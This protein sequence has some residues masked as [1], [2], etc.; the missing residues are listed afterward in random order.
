MTFVLVLSA[1]STSFIKDVKD[2]GGKK[3]EIVGTDNQG[4][5]MKSDVTQLF[6]NANVN[7]YFIFSDDESFDLMVEPKTGDDLTEDDKLEQQAL[8]KV[9]DGSLDGVEKTWSLRGDNEL[10]ISLVGEGINED[11]VFSVTFDKDIMKLTPVENTEEAEATDEDLLGLSSNA[12]L[13]KQA[14]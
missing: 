11:M 5:G 8:I 7:G 13:L 4:S 6:E 10:N 12:W 9:L 14:K 1:C 3:W 2:I